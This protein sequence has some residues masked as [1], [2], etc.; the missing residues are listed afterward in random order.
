MV[1]KPATNV[2]NGLY[3]RVYE[4]MKEN[5]RLEA[6]DTLLEIGDVYLIE[7]HL[8]CHTLKDLIEYMHELEYAVNNEDGRY[9]EGKRKKNYEKE[10]PCVID[11]IYTLLNG[12]NYY[13]YKEDYK[14]IGMK[15]TTEPNFIRDDKEFVTSF[16]NLVFNRSR[17]NLS[18]RNVITGKVVLDEEKAKNVGL[19]NEIESRIY[20]NHTIINDGVLNIDYIIALVDD[21]TFSELTLQERVYNVNLVEVLDEDYKMNEKSYRKVKIDLTDLDIVSR[22]YLYVHGTCREILRLTETRDIETVR[23]KIIKHYID[24]IKERQGEPS[25]FMGGKF[26]EKQ[27]EVLKDAGLDQ[28]GNYVGKKIEGLEKDEFY[29]ARSIEFQI[30]GQVNIPSVNAVLKKMNSGKKLNEIE[31]LMKEMLDTYAKYENDLDVLIEKLKETY[32]LLH[33]INL[34]LTAV[35]IAKI[36]NGAGFS[37]ATP[38]T[39]RNC[40][41]YIYDKLVIKANK[42]RVYVN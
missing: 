15:T 35:K 21:R 13:V 23:S 36:L 6:Y 17:L 24:K 40:L 37:D 4:L 39:D 12:D 20:R 28:Y 1:T 2:E 7:K 9:R 42:E 29:V 26:T 18:I 11:I 30:K 27:I 34:R 25:Y 14:R 32:R 10:S 33:G 38:I 22:D 5:R 19:P 3:K 31:S 8:H 41:K 16:S